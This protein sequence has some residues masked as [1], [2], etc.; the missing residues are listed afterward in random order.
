[1]FSKE[2]KDERGR[3]S[4]SL[5]DVYDNVIRP[6]ID[7]MDSFYELVLFTNLKSA[8]VRKHKRE[9]E[10]VILEYIKDHY[11][12]RRRIPITDKT[13][14]KQ[15]KEFVDLYVSKVDTYGLGITLETILYYIASNAPYLI[16]TPIYKEFQKL[17]EQ[18][19]NPDFFKRLDAHT[20]LYRYTEI[21]D[22]WSIR[23]TGNPPRKLRECK[24]GERLENGKCPV[25]PPI[26]K[27]IRQNTI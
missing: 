21:I 15:H 10:K 4:P 18:M 25:R 27:N 26:R 11:I 2:E 23:I 17:T 16:P 5:I 6:H 22:K 1:L 7:D 9:L 14:Q 24:Y 3:V 8:K 12:D 13:F 19:Y 20:A